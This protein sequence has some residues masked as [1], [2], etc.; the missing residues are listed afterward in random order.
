MEL[1]RSPLHMRIPWEVVGRGGDAVIA[2]H[3]YAFEQ[4]CI[5]FVNRNVVV[6]R[7]HRGKEPVASDVERGVGSR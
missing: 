5:V 3:A 1:L 2:Q 7:L 6:S 4:L